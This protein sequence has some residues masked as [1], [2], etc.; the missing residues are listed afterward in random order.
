[1]RSDS[2]MAQ[3]YL[4]FLATVPNY[5]KLTGVKVQLVFC[6]L[7]CDLPRGTFLYCLKTLLLAKP[8]NL[9]AILSARRKDAGPLPQ[10]RYC[11]TD[12]Y[13]LSLTQVSAGGGYSVSF[14]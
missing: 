8:S 4:K 14:Y 7:A 1:M 12:R 5:R 9:R 13:H 2:C 3:T 6:A 11:P 10:E